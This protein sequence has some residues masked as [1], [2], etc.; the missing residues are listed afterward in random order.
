MKRPMILADDPSTRFSDLE[1]EELSDYRP[2]N[3]Y[4]IVALILGLAS[5]LALTHPAL[6]MIPALGAIIS[7]LALRQFKVSETKQSGRSIAIIGLAASVMFASW[8]V[9]R[10]SSRQRYLFEHARQFA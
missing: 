6:L 2:L 10:E 5:G 7:L 1:P 9:A 8:S 4:A 3:R